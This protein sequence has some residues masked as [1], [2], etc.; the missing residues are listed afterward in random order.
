LEIYFVL[1]HQIPSD[2]AQ[3]EMAN[4]T[5]CFKMISQNLE[6]QNKRIKRELFYY[7]RCMTDQ[8]IEHKCWTL[9][10]KYANE[11][12]NS[13]KSQLV[14]VFIKTFAW[15]IPVSTLVHVKSGWIMHISNTNS[16][17]LFY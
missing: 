10:T 2:L 12:Q 7:F 15:L 8:I 17:C 14:S 1:S 16:I 5:T 13:I 6:P 9:H 4:Q 11:L 3:E